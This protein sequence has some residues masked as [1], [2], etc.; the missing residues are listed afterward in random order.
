LQSFYS[1]DDELADAVF[2]SDIDDARTLLER[3]ADPD[4]RDEEQRTPLM[5]A[6]LDG[7]RDLVRV[8]LEAGADPNLR[9]ADGWTP[10]DVAVY[11]QALDLI[12]L[13]V[14]FGADVNAQDDMGISVLMRAVLASKGSTEVVE[15][16]QRWGA[17]ADLPES[18]RAAALARDF[19][20]TIVHGNQL[21]AD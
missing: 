3:G 11:R 19:G 6:T 1:L 16:L 10:L 17:R 18:P 20:I 9:D 12:W 21:G 2:L 14:H 7:Q 5:N 8:L 15:L 13:L 4:A